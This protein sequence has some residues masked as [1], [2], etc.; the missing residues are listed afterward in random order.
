M[1]AVVAHGCW[2]RRPASSTT[3]KA[4]A[5][6]TRKRSPV[7]SP[8]Q[9]ST[10][11]FCFATGSVTAGSTIERWHNEITHSCNHKATR[12]ESAVL[13]GWQERGTRSGEVLRAVVELHLLRAGSRKDRR[14]G[15]HRLE[16]FRTRYRPSGGRTRL[17]NVVRDRGN[18]W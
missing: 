12:K 10:A 8:T 14:R 16:V 17:H 9:N 2:K 13:R 1:L 18:S 15:R 7:I 4:M 3:S 6:S 5:R 11:L